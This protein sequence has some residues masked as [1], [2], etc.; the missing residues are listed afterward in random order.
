MF[1]CERGFI[2]IYIYVKDSLNIPIK[3]KILIEVIHEF[4]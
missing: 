1:V 3:K 2:Y 4:T